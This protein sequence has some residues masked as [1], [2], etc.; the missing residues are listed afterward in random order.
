MAV[1]ASRDPGGLCPVAAV[2][3]FRRHFPERFDGGSQADQPVCRWSN[4]EPILRSEVATWLERAATAHGVPPTRMGTHSLRIGGASA[5][6]NAVGSIAIVKRFGRWRSEAF[7]GYLWEGDDYAKG[8]SAKMACHGGRLWAEHSLG[9]NAAAIHYGDG[10]VATP[11]LAA[12]G[13][14]PRDRRVTFA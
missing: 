10:P 4:G 5:L 1:F 3:E 12:P 9:A 13:A 6:M 14:N 8:M 7:Q 2:A 11:V